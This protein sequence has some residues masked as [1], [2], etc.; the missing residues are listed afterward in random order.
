MSPDESKHLQS[1]PLADLS[2]GNPL[3]KEIAILPLVVSLTGPQAQ[4]IHP[5]KGRRLSAPL[6]SLNCDPV[7]TSGVKPARYQRD[8][9][10][11]RNLLLSRTKPPTGSQRF[12]SCRG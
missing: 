2:T 6:C 7:G 4:P 5:T 12:N 10:L 9:P 3:A 11:G 1:Q 8:Y